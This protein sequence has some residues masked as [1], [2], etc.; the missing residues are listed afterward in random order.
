M[1][2]RLVLIG[3]LLVGAGTLAL[4][5]LGIEP[6][7]TWLFPILCWS[8]LLTLDALAQRRKGE[9]VL[10]AGGSATLLM[11]ADSVLFWMLFELA[12][13]RLQNWY[14]VNMPPVD[15]LRWAGEI[16]AAAAVVPGILVV[17][18]LLES[19]GLY[20][21]PPP[22]PI[23][24]SSRGERLALAAGGL[25]LGLALLVPTLFYPVIWIVPLLLLE[26]M[27]HR[28][29]EGCLLRD[30]EMGQTRRP[31]L[32]ASA[33]LLCGLFWEA[34]NAQGRAGWYHAIPG[35]DEPSY[36]RL[37]LMGL[38]GFLPLALSAYSFHLLMDGLRGG[39][40]YRL[41]EWFDE[42]EHRLQSDARPSALPSLLVTALVA[43]AGLFAVDRL[44]IDS[45]RCDADDLGAT[46]AERAVLK[47]YG[48]TDPFRLAEKAWGWRGAELAIDRGV[49]LGRI[50]PQIRR[51][52]LL[53]VGGIGPENARLLEAAGI[54]SIEHLAASP[55]QQLQERLAQVNGREKIRRRGPSIYK[56]RNWIAEA[57]SFVDR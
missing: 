57:R 50:E 19:Y 23:W 5:L 7:A 12:N 21:T 35:F 46:D 41:A 13:V 55:A 22:P 27:L 2:D 10:S 3:S 11:C 28:R 30:F 9:S 36:F 4:A 33:G 45:F 37:P 17:A 8:L 52:A 34:A 44:T 26:P 24:V 15:V 51:A 1:Q 39:R 6:A 42:R 20:S 49:P 38:L 48:L 18:D 53:T 25:A 47:A 32:L 16:V 56:V 14:Y 29:G 40:G 54:E 31:K 43:A